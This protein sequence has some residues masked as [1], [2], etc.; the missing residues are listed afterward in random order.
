MEVENNSVLVCGNGNKSWWVRDEDCKPVEHEAVEQPTK[1]ELTEAQKIAGRTLKAIWATQPKPEPEAVEQ[2][3]SDPVN[4]SHYKQERHRGSQEGSLVS[5]SVDSRGG[6]KVSKPTISFSGMT[7]DLDDVTHSIERPN[8]LMLNGFDINKIKHAEI[9]VEFKWAQH[10]VFK[11]GQVV[12]F[13]G[14]LCKV[15]SVAKDGSVTF[16]KLDERYCQLVAIGKDGS[17][18]LKKVEETK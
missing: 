2:P 3:T 11:V 6:N 8:G 16:E 7:F 14:H 1:R 9:A 13:D 12:R 15:V 5:R 17:I 4:P 10:H 18:T